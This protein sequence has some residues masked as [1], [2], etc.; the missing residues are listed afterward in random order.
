MSDRIFG[1]FGVFLAVIYALATLRIEESFLSD[2]VGPKTFP[3]G[4]AAILGLSSLVIALR[5]DSEP[6]W[7]G[8]GRLVEIFAAV[9]VMVLYAELLD[10]A[11]FIIATALATTYLTWRLGT[12]PVQSVLVGIATALGIYVI[13]HLVLGL[14]LARGPFGF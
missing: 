4:V 2:A 7:P 14:S 9:V 11:G 3:L 1:T 13:F 6:E 5:P 12:P 8:L 10:V